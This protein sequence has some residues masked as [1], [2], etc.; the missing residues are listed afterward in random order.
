MKYGVTL[1][2]NYRLRGNHRRQA[3]CTV[4][5]RF[6][7]SYRQTVGYR[8]SVQYRCGEDYRQAVLGRQNAN[9]V[10]RKV[11]LAHSLS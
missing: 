11:H 8:Q 10:L 1:P 7:I 2:P 9:S 3:T 5:Y 6:T 4:D